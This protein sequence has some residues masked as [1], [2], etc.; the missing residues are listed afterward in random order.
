MIPLCAILFAHVKSAGGIP[1]RV[2]SVVID[3]LRALRL[4]AVLRYSVQL[5]HD[6][7]IDDLPLLC[8]TR[9]R[10]LPSAD[11]LHFTF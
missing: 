2:K 4:L 7:R 11:H 1:D 3:V 9:L 5:E 8:A 10:Q 6:V